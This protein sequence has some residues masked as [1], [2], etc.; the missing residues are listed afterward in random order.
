MQ[1]RYFSVRTLGKRYAP[2]G[3]DVSSVTDVLIAKGGH[4]QAGIHRASV[5]VVATVLVGLLVPALAR[6][7][8]RTVADGLMHAVRSTSPPSATGKAATGTS[9]TPAARTVRSLLGSCRRA[10]QWPG[11]STRT[12]TGRPIGLPRYSG[13]TVSPKGLRPQPADESLVNCDLGASAA[14]AAQ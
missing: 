8:T 13:S 4:M 6:A 12:A 7:E 2:C 10:A 1:R 14:L 9:S 3:C 11:S 5:F